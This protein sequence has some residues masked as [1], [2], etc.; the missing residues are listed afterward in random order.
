[1]KTTAQYQHYRRPITQFDTCQRELCTTLL[2]RLPSW[3]PL[4]YSG[5][6]YP[7]PPMSS[8]PSP[9]KQPLERGGVATQESSPQDISMI[10]VISQQSHHT[11]TYP[12]SSAAREPG[13]AAYQHES[14]SNQLPYTTRDSPQS[15]RKDQSP[16]HDEPIG[17]PS[18]SESEANIAGPSSAS[19]GRAGR[20]SKAH[21][22]NACGNCKRAHLS[23]DVQ[24]PCNRCIATGKQVSHLPVIGMPLAVSTDVAGRIHVEMCHTRR[25]VALDSGRTLS[26]ELIRPSPWQDH[27]RAKR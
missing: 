16:P 7:S 10:S 21:V 6:S 25:G 3:G 1:M 4:W 17:R 26:S 2:P 15:T 13:P 8:P 5:L 14:P 24:R 27:S 20:R 11:F 18:P 9:P 19:A 23:C 12:A 22:A